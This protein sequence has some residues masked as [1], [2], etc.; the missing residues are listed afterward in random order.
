MLKYKNKKQ[1]V[2][3]SLTELKQ[4]LVTDF[5]NSSINVKKLIQKYISDHEQ[6]LKL[7]NIN[8]LTTEQTEQLKKLHNTIYYV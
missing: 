2:E 5:K 6:Y 4:M 3:Q 7:L 1:D 8:N